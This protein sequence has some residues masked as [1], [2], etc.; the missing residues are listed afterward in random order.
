MTANAVRLPLAGAAFLALADTAI[1]AL[2]LP[3]ILRELDTDVAGVAAVLGVY[4][5]VLAVALPVAER[6]YASRVG[7]RAVGLGGGGAVRGRVAGVRASR[8]T[9]SLLLAAARCRRWA[10]R[11][12]W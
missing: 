2:A 12:C 10:A 4:A 8:T 5:V 6:G 1:V 7:T 9:S 3:P 11:R